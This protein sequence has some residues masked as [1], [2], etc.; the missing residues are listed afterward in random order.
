MSAL[1]F[2]LL[3]V[4]DIDSLNVD[5]HDEMVKLVGGAGKAMSSGIFGAF[6]A[7]KDRLKFAFE[8]SPL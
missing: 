1:E 4:V 8:P 5:T 6:S 7:P 2:L 3:V